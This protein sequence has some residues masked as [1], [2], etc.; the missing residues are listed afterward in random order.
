MLTDLNTT[1]RGMFEERHISNYV[2]EEVNVEMRRGSGCF[3]DGLRE[4]MKNLSLYIRLPSRD[5]K[6]SWSYTNPFG[7]SAQ[8]A[9]IEKQ[10]RKFGHWR[11]FDVKLFPVFEKAFNYFL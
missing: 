9:W 8:K 3:V 11:L 10:F 1:E 5:S 2:G 6:Q 4:T 7:L